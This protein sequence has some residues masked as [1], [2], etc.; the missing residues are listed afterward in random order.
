M[1][2][3]FF[4]LAFL[5]HVSLIHSQKLTPSDLTLDQYLQ[6]H[7]YNLSPEGSGSKDNYALEGFSTDAQREQFVQLLKLHP[8]VTDV[9]EIGLNGGHSA[10]VFLKHCPNL[11]RFVSIDIN[12]HSY[13]ARAVEYLSKKYQGKFTFIAGDSTVKVPEFGTLHP[14]QKFDLIFIDGNHNYNYCLQDILNTRALTRSNA[15]LIID[16]YDNPSVQ[17]AVR[18]CQEMQVIEVRGVFHSQDLHGFRSW[19]EARYL[20]SK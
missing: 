10:E 15:L 5:L 13:T 17:Q 12:W 2:L 20:D 9:L 6:L 14:E 8:H 19:V 4:F 3:R 16:D 1:F 11:K 7:G 18:K